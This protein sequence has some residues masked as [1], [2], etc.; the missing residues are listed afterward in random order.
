MKNQLVGLRG[1]MNKNTKYQTLTNILDA[2]CREATEKR[3]IYYP[4]AGAEQQLIQARSRAYLHLF[5]KVK[6]GLLDFEEREKQITDGPH[7]GGID[8][9]HIES[10]EKIIYCLQSK[11]RANAENF[12]LNQVSA[13]DLVKIELSQVLK[14]NATDVYGSHYNKAIRGFQKKIR[15]IP[16]IGRYEYKIVLLGN[17]KKLHKDQLRR[18]CDGFMIEQYDHT[19][20]YSELVFPVVNGVYFNRPD[21]TIKLNLTNV[22]A[23]KEHLNYSVKAEGQNA[24]VMLLFVPTIEIGRVLHTYRNSILRFNPRSYLE[25]HNN[26]VNRGIHDSIVQ[27]YNNEFALFNNGITL[28]S[29]TTKLNT[30]VGEKGAGQLFVTNPQIINGGQ[31]AFTLS[32]VYEDVVAEKLNKRVFE[33][34]EVL[35]RVITFARP[36]SD[37]DRAKQARQARQILI[38]DISKASNSQTKI[39]EADRRSNEKIQIDLQRLFFGDFG[40]FYERKRGEFADGLRA[41]Y[42]GKHLIVDREKLMRVALAVD[43]RASLAKTSVKKFFSEETFSNSPLH[44][45]NIDRLVFGYDVLRRLEAARRLPS[46]K[47]THGIRKYGNALKYGQYAVVA[48]AVSACLPR[49]LLPEQSVETILSQWKKYEKWVKKRRANRHYFSSV[50]GGGFI[51]YYKGSTLN[52]DLASFPFIVKKKRDRAIIE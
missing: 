32:R 37:L 30:E 11:F 9:F 31:T 8:A 48:A 24:D 19:R 26:P 45:G 7:D 51:S 3:T 36:S 17:S 42:I 14:G 52:H 40:L 21:L 49:G 33:G 1:N 27:T 20:I 44:A 50:N 34:K 2:L 16:D 23:G 35:L 22:R 5:L 38:S 10:D 46:N 4:K 25:L 43:S 18:L 39:E 29:D 15:N 6:F 28:L 41:G 12:R 47:N 13:D